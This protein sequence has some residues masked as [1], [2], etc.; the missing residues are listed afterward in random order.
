[1]GEIFLDAE[2]EASIVNSYVNS[3]KQKKEPGDDKKGKEEKSKP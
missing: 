1:M 3:L 2:E